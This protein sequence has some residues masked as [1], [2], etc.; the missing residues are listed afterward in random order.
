MRKTATF[1]TAECC[2]YTVA[3]VLAASDLGAIPIR[4]IAPDVGEYFTAGCLMAALLRRHGWE[5]MLKDFSPF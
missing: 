1:N 5:V 3:D 2:D 4:E